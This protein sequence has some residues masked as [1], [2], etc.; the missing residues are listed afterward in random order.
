MIF[1]IRKLGYITDTELNTVE[2]MSI[3]VGRLLSGLRKSL[4]EKQSNNY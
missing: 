3:E 1:S 4:I 2:D